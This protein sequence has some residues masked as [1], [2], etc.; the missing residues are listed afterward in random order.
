[1][2]VPEGTPLCNPELNLYLNKPKVRMALH[3]P[4]HVGTWKFCSLYNNYTQTDSDM[5]PQIRK[6]VNS[7]AHVLLYYGDTDLA[8]NFIGGQE[9]SNALENN[10]KRAW[11]ING[12]LGGFAT[13][14][15]KNLTYITVR[16]VGHMVPQWQPKGALYFMQ[17][18]LKNEPI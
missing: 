8:C 6:I 15:E 7:G 11:T 16:G 12:F 17:Q 2:D 5:R 10:D 18:F 4:A 13:E 1:M 9:F 3:I 14:Y